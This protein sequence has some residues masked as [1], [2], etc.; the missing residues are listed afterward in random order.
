MSLLHCLQHKKYKTKDNV[1]GF[2][3]TQ[4]SAAAAYVAIYMNAESSKLKL[5]KHFFC[6]KYKLYIC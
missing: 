6:K 3:L 1:G 2:R 5:F 4:F